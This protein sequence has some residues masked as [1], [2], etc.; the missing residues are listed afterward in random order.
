[1]SEGLGGGFDSL[2]L[3]MENLITREAM[4]TKGP[5]KGFTGKIVQQDKIGNVVIE[6]AAKDRRWAQLKQIVTI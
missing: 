2:V 4:I 6:N 3:H 1:M 5:N